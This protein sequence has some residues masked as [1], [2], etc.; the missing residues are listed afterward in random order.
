MRGSSARISR[1]AFGLA[2]ARVAACSRAYRLNRQPG[3]TC[4][5]IS[6][7]LLRQRQRHE[8]QQLKIQRLHFSASERGVRPELQL[9]WT[10]TSGRDCRP[11]PPEPPSCALRATNSPRPP[12]RV[13]LPRSRC[14]MRPT[15]PQGVRK[16][17][18]PAI[19]WYYMFAALT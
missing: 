3:H 19:F 1:S 11:S 6:S 13:R 12:A 14:G 10:S 16:A 2:K 5:R 8:R 15:F 9:A 17:S 4:A 7:Q 18:Q